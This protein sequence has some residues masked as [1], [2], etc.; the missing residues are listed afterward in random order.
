[1]EL[2]TITQARYIDGYRI[3]AVFSNGV[4]KIIDFAPIIKEGKGIVSKLS[5]I[6]YFKNFTL[7]P[8][9][10][11]WND[12]IGFDPHDLYEHGEKIG[13]GENIPEEAAVLEDPKKEWRH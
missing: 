1:M 8:F 2:L 12:E 9:T 4:K 3:E 6:E 7:D 13:Y 10:I 5:N 11:D